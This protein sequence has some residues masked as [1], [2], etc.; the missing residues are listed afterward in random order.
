[1]LW[2]HF[3]KTQPEKQREFEKKIQKVSTMTLN[4]MIMYFKTVKEKN[5]NLRVK[6]RKLSTNDLR[7]ERRGVAVSVADRDPLGDN[8]L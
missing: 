6:C 5:T 3:A 7:I 8:A 4:S 1:M 2:I